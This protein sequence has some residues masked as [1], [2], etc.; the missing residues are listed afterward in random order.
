M[1]VTPHFAL[2]NRKQR[3]FVIEP[4]WQKWSPPCLIKTT[5]EDVESGKSCTE[6]EYCRMFFF[7]FATK[8]F[9]KSHK[10]DHQQTW[11]FLAAEVTC[12]LELPPFAKQIYDGLQTRVL[13]PSPPP[14][15]PPVS[16]HSCWESEKK[17]CNT[18]NHEAHAAFNTKQC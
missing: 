12:T 2:R 6:L 9:K 13:Q 14:P 5:T 7:S 15:P 11:L 17:L 8:K 4:H 10:S 16:S 1:V 3:Y 18:V